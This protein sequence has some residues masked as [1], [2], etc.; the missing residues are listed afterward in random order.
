VGTILGA[1]DI[2]CLLDR[3]IQASFLALLGVTVSFDISFIRYAIMG[4]VMILIIGFRPQGLI[5]GG[6]VKIPLYDG[7]KKKLHSSEKNQGD[8]W[9]I[10]ARRDIESDA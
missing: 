2:P 6:V 3:F 10:Y 4:L 8:L 9:S 7:I 1:S 5:P